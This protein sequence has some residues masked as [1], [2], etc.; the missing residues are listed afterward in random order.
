M[1][2]YQDIV[3]IHHSK[4]ERQRVIRGVLLQ[5]RGEGTASS[6]VVSVRG[7]RRV[8]RRTWTVNRSPHGNKTARQQ[9]GREQWQRRRRRCGM[10]VS[11]Q[12]RKER[13]NG[14]GRVAQRR[15]REV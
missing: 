14:L 9:R 6:P 8:Q 10:A 3:R 15:R 2:D 4:E 5:F 1:K 11:P 12:I 13:R 7:C